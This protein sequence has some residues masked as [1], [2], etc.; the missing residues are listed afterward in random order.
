LFNF[1]DHIDDPAFTEEWG[2][3]SLS[4]AEVLLAM[5]QTYDLLLGSDFPNNITQ[6]DIRE[7]RFDLPFFTNLR[8]KGILL[9]RGLPAAQKEL[10][11]T[12]ET[13][14]ASLQSLTYLHT[15]TWM[16]VPNQNHTIRNAAALGTS[17]LVLNTADN[18]YEYI[19]L[20]M[21]AI[22]KT[23]GIGAGGP[24]NDPL[25]FTKDVEY[26]GFA[27]GPGYLDYSAEL[28][29][30][31]MLA[32]KQFI[33][34]ESPDQ[35][36]AYTN[37]LVQYDM[38]VPEMLSTERVRKIDEWSLRIA[39]PSGR[40]PD[41]KD[42]DVD[43]NF[44]SGLLANDISSDPLDMKKVWAAAFKQGG[45]NTTGTR[46]HLR[47][48]DHFVYYDDT[49][50]DDTVDPGLV[51]ESPS[52]ANAEEGSVVMRSDWSTNALYLYLIADH[53]WDKNLSGGVI[54]GTRYPAHQQ[55][56]NT[57]F[58]VYG[59]GD[60]LAIDSGYGGF[61]LRDYVSKAANHNVVLVDGEGPAADT[62]AY[63]TETYH[64]NLVEAATVTSDYQGTG[65]TRSVLF[66]DRS[67]FVVVDDLRSAST[68][69]YDWQ[70][71]GNNN[72]DAAGS[73]QAFQGGYLWTTE[74]QSQNL[75]VHV[76]NTSANGVDQ[77]IDDT[78]YHF[79]QHE[80]SADNLKK[81]TAIQ[82]REDAAADLKYVAAL[83]PSDGGTASLPAVV[84]YTA[85]G[86]F[87]GLGISAAGHT[88]LIAAGDPANTNPGPYEIASAITGL[89]TVRT[90]AGFLFLR[91]SKNTNALLGFYGKDMSFLEF[92]GRSVV[93]SPVCSPPTSGAWNVESN[94]TIADNVVIQGDVVVASGVELVIAAGADLDI[95]LGS[96]ALRIRPGGRLIVRPGGKLH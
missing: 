79:L 53:N 83:F 68:H 67:Y 88:D 84:H 91:V 77:V 48:V 25:L 13:K 32:Y 14:L 38:A 49:L 2:Q 26:G 18:A 23:L 4:T 90:D 1:R 3:Q 31:F 59:Y 47:L 73:F 37:W 35:T 57:S 93:I 29:L 22:W 34:G 41:I 78:A 82:A 69:R 44:Y 43:A 24:F 95:D 89:P 87:A 20:A 64:S 5:S 94:C 92:A 9:L 8:V 86:V 46:G 76:T 63:L 80:P 15:H 28:Y 81:H 65:L 58:L 45:P 60:Y 36:F 74:A 71:H 85:P 75:L 70:L 39:T 66:V 30:P 61:P 33:E 72:P 62:Q 51:F 56:D 50:F 21:T 17:A 54:G 7:N 27:E 42:T 16:L 96:H 10:R 6:Q 40:P 11:K 12:A 19:S 55:A 52:Y